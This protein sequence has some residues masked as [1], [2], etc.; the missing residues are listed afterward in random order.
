MPAFQ[1]DEHV[2]R[3]D[4]PTEVESGRD[5]PRFGEALGQQCHVGQ[6]T[7]LPRAPQPSGLGIDGGGAQGH[8]ED[9]TAA[10]M[11]G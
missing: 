11:E 2:E 6:V 10:F 8:R 1:A 4:R 7:L 3:S 5:H 9:G